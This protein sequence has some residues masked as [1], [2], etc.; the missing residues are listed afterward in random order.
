MRTLVPSLGVYITRAY[1]VGLKVFI[2]LSN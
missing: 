1:M 2:Q